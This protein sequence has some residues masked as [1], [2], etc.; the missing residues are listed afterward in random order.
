MGA[1]LANR[2]EVKLRPRIHIFFQL[3]VILLLHTYPMWIFFYVE[4]YFS[5]FLF[6]NLISL[7]ETY[8]FLIAFIIRHTLHLLSFIVLS[9]K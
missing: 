1:M 9:F 3:V 6:C 4:G 7:Y 8:S 2:G 5:N